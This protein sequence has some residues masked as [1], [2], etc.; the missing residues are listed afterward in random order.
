MKNEGVAALA[1]ALGVSKATV[2]RAL[3]HKSGVD[4]ATREKILEAAGMRET[5][6]CEIYA[7]LPDTPSYFWREMRGALEEAALSDT[8]ERT[9]SCN[10]YTRLKDSSS[11]CRYLVEAES[12][13]V[14]IAAASVTDETEE[15]FSELSRDKLVIYLSEGEGVSGVYVG[16]NPEA[17]GRALAGVYLGDAELRECPAVVLTLGG[18]SNRNVDKKCGAFLDELRNNGRE[19]REVIRL[20]SEFLKPSKTFPARAA[21]L[22]KSVAERI[23]GRFVL[24]SALGYARLP[25]ALEKSRLS[26]KA[27]LLCHDAP[28]T[29]EGAPAVGVYAS[30]C[31]NVREQARAAYKAACAYLDGEDVRGKIYIESSIV[32]GYPGVQA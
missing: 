8:A 15:M 23:D 1:A 30:A 4:S 16:S 29:E 10:V 9:L 3:G 20:E 25:L 6:P 14:V 11:V 2:S 27:V 24:Y 7:L 19:A 5:P 21:S 28:L 13:K 17:D 26:E 32:R 18:Q 31:Q 12:A 22:L